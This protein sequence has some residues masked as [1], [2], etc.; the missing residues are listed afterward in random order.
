MR[1]APR[2]HAFTLVEM[3]VVI[4]IIGILTA[5]A[6]PTL[7]TMRGSDS[8]LATT[9]QLLDDCTRAR[10]F[11]ISQ[12]TTVFMVF[13]PDNFWNDPNYAKLN[14][15]PKEISKAQN[16]WDKQLAAYSFVTLR[17]V[18]DQPG[19]STVRYLSAWRSL[20]EGAF[21]PGFKFNARAALPTQIYD[22][23]QSAPPA[24]TLPNDRIFSVKGFDRTVDVPFPSQD[25]SATGAP[26][27]ALPYIAFNHLGQLTRDGVN[28]SQ[29]DEFIPLAKGSVDYSRDAKKNPVQAA[30]TLTESPAGSS[31]NTFMLVHIDWLTGRAR[32]EKQE[33]R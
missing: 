26:Y 1:T 14:P 25:A 31:T 16:L 15:Y 18:G 23:P 5:I 3:L 33:F 17:S 29:E 13:C 20:P 11:A 2:Q 19:R 30:P 7:K 27:V 10:Q 22:P 8:T 21:I 32:L 4:S 24:P 9:R 28:A 6:L 12:R